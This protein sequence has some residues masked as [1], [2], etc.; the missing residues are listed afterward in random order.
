MACKILQTHHSKAPPEGD[1]T[2]FR[3]LD[4]GCGICGPMHNSACFTQCHIIGLTLNPY[5][6]EHGNEQADVTVKHLSVSIQGDFMEMPFD[7]ETFDTAYAIEATC[8]APD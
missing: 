1:E 4:V 7:S 3:I 8:H 2:K 6:V 5:Q